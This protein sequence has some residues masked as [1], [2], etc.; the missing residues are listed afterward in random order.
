MLFKLHVQLPEGPLSHRINLLLRSIN[1]E[2]QILQDRTKLSALGALHSS[3]KAIEQSGLAAS[4]YDY[5][6]NSI[7]RLFHRP[8]H[9]EDRLAAILDQ[10][11]DILSSNDAPISLLLIALVEQWPYLER[12]ETVGD[13]A[14]LVA[15]KF[16][17]KLLGYCKRIGEDELVMT[18]LRKELL[19][20]PGHD[21]YKNI[22]KTAL[23]QAPEIGEDPFDIA[24]HTETSPANSN[25]HDVPSRPGSPGMDDMDEDATEDL[26]GA[27]Y[28]DPKALFSWIHKDVQDAVEDGDVAG[29]IRC[30][31]SSELRIR[32]QALSGLAKLVQKLESSSYLEK[33][34]MIL[35]LQETIHTAKKI[36]KEHPFSTY[37][38]E[39]AG[40]AVSV[41]ADPQHPLYPK[42]NYFLHE[43]PVWDADRIPLTH[44]IL[45]QPPEEDG[46]HHKEIEWFLDLVIDGLRTNKV[47]LMA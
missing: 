6:D 46:T 12:S 31:S 4:T 14:K 26:L 41:E 21:E 13:A 8:V 35:L 3:L 36:V 15:A 47:Q 42:L 18:I 38:A 30:L 17:A 1:K 32:M 10:S 23:D 29:L 22:F 2:T 24:V 16:L 5:L 27:N 7:I 44:K 39:F 25:K 45:L 11:D 40:R 33:Q 37:L 43:G 28:E 19:K 20:G 9:Y 34:P